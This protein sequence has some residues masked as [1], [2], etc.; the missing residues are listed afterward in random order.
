MKLH[1]LKDLHA[2]NNRSGPVFSLIVVAFLSLCLPEIQINL[3]FV[4]AD[5]ITLLRTETQTSYFVAFAIFFRVR[6]PIKGSVEE[7]LCECL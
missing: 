6:R 5:G 1:V 2:P 3:H 4:D 7:P